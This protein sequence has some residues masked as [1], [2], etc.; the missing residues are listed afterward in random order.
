MSKRKNTILALR[1]L[2]KDL[3]RLYNTRLAKEQEKELYEEDD[4]TEFDEEIATINRSIAECEHNIACHEQTL[5]YLNSM[6]ETTYS[7]ALAYT[8]LTPATI[9][10]TDIEDRM[11]ELFNEPTGFINKVDNVTTYNLE[12]AKKYVNLTEHDLNND[13][14]IDHLQSVYSYMH[15]GGFRVTDMDLIPGQFKISIYINEPKV[16]DNE[17]LVFG[18][19]KNEHIPKPFNPEFDYRK[20]L[21]R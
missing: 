12:K 8:A 20:L 17:V 3:G 9:M 1:E 10:E 16:S 2:E 19:S 11:Q 21:K 7:N 18:T 6:T 15:E 5:E 4:P 14:I 13:H